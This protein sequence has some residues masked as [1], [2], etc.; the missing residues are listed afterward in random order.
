M[1][2]AIRRV[3]ADVVYSLKTEVAR[4]P[5]VGLPLER[6][7]GRGNVIDE[8]TDIVIEGFPRCASSF[9]VAA[10][11]L[12]QEPNAM[13]VA[14]HTHMP[15]QVIH[16]VRRGIPTMV[17]IRPAEAAVVSLLIRNHFLSVRTALRG[18]VRFYE[19][20]VPFAGGFVTATFDEIVHDLG[21]P[22]ER[23]NSMFGTAFAPFL[24]TPANLARIAREIEDDYR[25]RTDDPDRLE[26]IIPRPSVVRD[27]TKEVVERRFHDEAPQRDLRRATAVYR[28]LTI[29]EP[30][31][32]DLR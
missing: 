13:N 29:R 7:R 2:A 20:L 32:L 15:A 24:H 31:A 19:T 10:F 12:A 27:R 18:Y 17:L 5:S 21:E 14:D 28:S 16:G 30:D 3:A 23:L 26:R 22:I 8:A 9:V 4:Y 25:T 1:N 11:R 6:I